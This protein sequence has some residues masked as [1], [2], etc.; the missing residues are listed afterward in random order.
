MYRASNSKMN[1]HEV[2]NRK[3]PPLTSTAKQVVGERRQQPP[4]GQDQTLGNCESA[5]GK[6]QSCIG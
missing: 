5:M 3:Q 1:V 4:R 6:G 2:R